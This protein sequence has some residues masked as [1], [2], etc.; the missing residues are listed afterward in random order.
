MKKFVV[1]VLLVFMSALC[2]AQPHYYAGPGDGI[3]DN[4]APFNAAQAAVCASP[5]RE[6]IVPAGAF[7][8][9]SPPAAPTCTIDLV[10]ASKGATR[11]IK[12]FSS[13]V[14]WYLLKREQNAVD[15]YGGGAIRNCTIHAGSGSTNG[16]A[17]WVV[18]T[19]DTAGL[20]A[21]TKNPH[22][23]L[24]DNVMISHDV[25]GGVFGFG[26]YLDGSLNPGPGAVG[27][28]GINIRDTSVNF[29]T[30]ADF[31]FNNAKGVNMT[32]VD[33]YGTPTYNLGLDG[34]SDGILIVSRTCNPTLINVV[35]GTVYKLP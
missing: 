15:T 17:I 9:L 6:L 32:G 18:A 33:C 27:I 5:N 24:I 19:P 20:S 31:Y 10:C 35:S 14:G 12:D 34:Q 21:T 4:A 16:M 13:P 28:R 1:S 22:G 26:V 29:A 8:F 11:L 7:R 2:F 23:L 25:G 30:T 3:T